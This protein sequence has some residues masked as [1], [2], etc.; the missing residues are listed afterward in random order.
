MY[1]STACAV[2]LAGQE[3]SAYEEGGVEKAS[4]PVK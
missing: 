1:I 4:N 2:D 3:R